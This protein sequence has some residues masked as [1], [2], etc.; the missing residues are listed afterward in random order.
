MVN[1]EP[2]RKFQAGQVTCA[3]WDNVVMVKGKPVTMTKATVDRRYQGNDG[4]WKTSQSFSRN[5][6]P[7][8]I[9]VL[10]KAFEAMVEKRPDRDQV[11]TEEEVL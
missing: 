9:Y 3:L 2:I 10:S 1:N 8:A 4:T 7:L 11:M 6:I 5:E